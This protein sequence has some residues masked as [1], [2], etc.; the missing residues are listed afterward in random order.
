MNKNIKKFLFSTTLVSIG[1]GL[2]IIYLEM[3]SKSKLDKYYLDCLI[4][5]KSRLINGSSVDSKKSIEDYEEKIELYMHLDG[6]N[7]IEIL[8][9]KCK[10]LIE[11]IK[12]GKSK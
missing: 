10:A 3:D 5:V 1:F 8:D 11:V 7:G 12:E 2:G 4:V 9:M 6:Y